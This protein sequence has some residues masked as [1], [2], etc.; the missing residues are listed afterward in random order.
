MGNYLL[1]ELMDELTQLTK[2]FEKIFL[3]APDVALTVFEQKLTLLETIGKK[4]AIYYNKRD[5]VLLVS[6]FATGQPRLGRKGTSV[7]CDFIELTD[8]THEKNK[9]FVGRMMQHSYFRTSP[10]VRESLKKQ[11]NF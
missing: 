9:T 8:C 5:K 3:M 2:P 7:Q 10:V 1:F 6:R 4:T 11:I